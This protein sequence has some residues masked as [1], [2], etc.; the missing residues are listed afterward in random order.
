[1]YMILAMIVALWL[2]LVVTVGERLVLDSLR[3][4][5]L[6]QPSGPSLPEIVHADRPCTLSTMIQT[7]LAVRSD[8]LVQQIWEA[9]ASARVLL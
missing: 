7:N 2:A 3:A 8:A 1:M 5:R 6:G 9:D 4:S